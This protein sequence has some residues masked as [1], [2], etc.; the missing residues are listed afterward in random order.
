DEIN[1]FVSK[2]PNQQSCSCDTNVGVCD[3]TCG[4]DWDCSKFT[5]VGTKF[6]LTN[7]VD[8]Q[9]CA[10]S[11]LETLLSFFDGILGIF[12][13]TNPYL[14]TVYIDSKLATS[15]SEYTVL[16]NNA[17]SQSA[18]L[19]A[20]TKSSMSDDSSSNYYIG[21]PVQ[22]DPSSSYPYF[23]INSNF[24]FGS[25]CDFPQVV[26]FGRNFE[27]RCIIPLSI[28]KCAENTNL[29]AKFFAETQIP[30]IL[31]SPNSNYSSLVTVNVEYCQN[32]FFA[33][34]DSS[35]LEYSNEILNIL[36]NFSKVDREEKCASTADSP[37]LTENTT[38]CGNVL[39][40]ICHTFYWKD[41]LIEN[42]RITLKTRNLL[43][44]ESS[45]VQERR[46][47]WKHISEISVVSSKYNFPGEFCG[48]W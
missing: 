29:D 31:S 15:N 22:N 44:S 36:Q 14:D 2:I 10:E 4:C 17:T 25:D 40:N 35:A 48:L 18:N 12:L 37:I 43:I 19:E 13:E 11:L 9:F 27:T 21:R 39:S 7:T 5:T 8:R 34:D 3:A 42:L 46:I 23:H 24:G 32:S 30:R 16:W 28:E 26:R 6:P 20:Y 1:P 33:V 38:I 41:G 47:E 45:F